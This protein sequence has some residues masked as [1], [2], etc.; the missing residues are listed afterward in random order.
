MPLPSRS[1]MRM[2]WSVAAHSQYRFGEKHRAWMMSPCSQG[3]E[4][5]RLPSFKSHSMATPSLP[6]EAHREP[7]GETVTA[8][9]YPECPTRLVRSLQLD[10]FQTLTILSH[11]PDTMAGFCWFGTKFTQET[12]SECPSLVP[13]SP[14]VYL[15]SPRVFQSLIVL[16]RE[17]ET[18]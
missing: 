13:C 12:H 17:A 16:S 14:M 15:H 9:M 5:R 4:Y 6:P 2:P 18:I 3:R 10:M 7:S 11:P 8:L 1:Q